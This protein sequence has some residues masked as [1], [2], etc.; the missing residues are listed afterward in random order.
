MAITLQVDDTIV[1]EQIDYHHAERLFEL[2][3]VNRLLLREWLPWV[4]HMRTLDDFRNF[5]HQAKQ[6]HAAR[7]ETGFVIMVQHTMAG[8]IG[9]YNMDWQ[10][11][12]ASIGYWLD[13]QH[14]G[15]GIMTRCCQSLIRYCFTGLGLNRI[16]IRCGTANTK[17]QAIPERLHFKNEGT[18]RQ[19]EFVNNAFIDLHIY[20]LIREEWKEETYHHK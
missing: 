9:L 11:K 6:R 18:I 14:Q 1:L 2:V 20:A 3:K 19:A 17:S 13:E 12:T 10:H 4:D 16:E 15:R 7:T 5:I 8:R